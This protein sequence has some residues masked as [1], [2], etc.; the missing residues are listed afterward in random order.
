MSTVLDI[1]K[2]INKAWKTDVLTPGD[3]IPECA[4]FSMGTMS[5]DYALYGGLPE[6][7]LVVYAGASGSCKSLLACLAM[8]QYQKKHPDRTC[9]YVDAEETLVGQ[10]EFFVRMT[11][12]DLSPERFM[13][14][15]CTGKSAE[16]IF[17]DIIQLQTADN[18]GMIIIDSAP[19]L[20]SQADIDN[21]ITK[22]NGQRASIAK[23][24]GKFLKMMVPAISKAGNTLLIINHTRVAGTTF[25]GAKIYTEPCGYALDFYPCIKVRFAN[26]KFTKGD[27]IDINA[28]QTD[29]DTDGIVATFSVTK[30]RLGALNRNGAK[31][32]FRFD[33]GVDT[34]TDLVEIIT[35]HEIAK[36]LS[37][38]SWQL[39]YPGTDK[40]YVDENGNPLQF[41]G[42]GKM[43]DYIKTHPDFRS[44]YE[45]DVSAYI[46]NTGKDI[47]LIDEEDLQMILEM[48]KSTD[49]TNEQEKEDQDNDDKE[50]TD[51]PVKEDADFG[52]GND[53]TYVASAPIE[54]D[55]QSND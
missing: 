47:S 18:I 14:Y 23:S 15:D 53:V 30:N 31:I 10:V 16:E 33:S 21:D 3:L 25:T 5:A 38:V 9:V 13:R 29:S 17:S 12:L 40:P 26:R 1:A 6:G 52:D 37:T 51:L 27:N 7:K 46:N 4:R 45:A 41:A 50:N 32:I 24:M 28:S 11:G 39:V 48:E 44:M 36:R 42:K 43:I 2:S 22:D 34:L 55:E 20:I 8:A 19:M 49:S 54:S 35:K